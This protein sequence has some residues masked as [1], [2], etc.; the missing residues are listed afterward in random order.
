MFALALATAANAQTTSGSIA[1]TVTDPNQAAIASA[2]V[3]ITDE[4]KNFT[5]SATTDGDGR[6]VFPQVPPG[7][8]KMSIEGAGFKKLE[9]TG[10]LLVAND[11]LTLGGLAMQVGGASE[12]VT[13][14][15]EATLVQAES[16]ERSYAVQGEVV[17]NIAVNGRNFAALASI[18]QGLVTTTNNTTAN[19]ITDISANGL[20]TSANNLQIDGVATVDT[21]NNGQLVQVTLDAIAE[22]KVLTSNYQAEYGRSAGAQISAVTRSG[23][24]DFHGSFY[25]F[26]RHDGLNANTWINNHTPS[27]D[28]AGNPR[29]FTPKPKLDQRDIGYTIGGPVWIPKVFNKNKDKL[30]FFFSQE[31]QHR[32]TPPTGPT[33]VT[34]PTALERLGDFSQSVDASGAR[35]FIGDPTKK[36][37]NGNRLPCTAANTVDNLGG[38]FVSNGKL[39]VIPQGSIYQPGLNILKIYPLP[40]ANGVGFNYVTEEP[41]SAPQR[42]DLIRIDGNISNNWRANGKYLFYKNAPVQPYGSFVLGTNIPDFATVF[43]NNRYGVTGTVTGSLNPTTVLEVTFGQSHNSIDIL[44]TNPNFNRKGLNLTGVPL[45]FNDPVQLDLPPQFIF[46]GNRIANGP[47]IGSNNAPFHNFNTTRDF[48]G[49]VSK[50]WRAHNAKF[51]VFWQNSFKPQ[52]SFGANNGQYNFVNDASNPFDTGFGFSNAAVGVYN[53]FTQA[54]VYAVGNYRYNNV[55]WYAQDNWKVTSRLTLDYGMRFYW[56]QPQFDESSQTANFLFDQFR[57]SDAPRLYRPSKDAKGNR[58]G[59]DPVTG[60]TVDATSI[61]RIVPGTGKLA[62]GVPTNGVFKAGDNISQ[63]LYDNRGVQFAP[64]FGFAYDV[65]GD[66]KLVVRGGAGVFYDRPQGN[67]VF[68]LVQ[69]PP[70]YNPD[71]ALLRADTGYYPTH[72]GGFERGQGAGRA[73]QPGRHRPE[74]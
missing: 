51:G 52:S 29:N 41:T 64:R 44:P 4:S 28:E 33:R 39:N 27:A 48:A 72:A 16:A 12:T 10:I 9:R 37:A 56:I 32:L 1:G 45:L 40:N 57:A 5:I 46:N 67:T 62:N 31:Y 23:T 54:S 66:Q 53:Q 42:Q 15:A 25:A 58:I 30:F 21:G 70:D 43:Q 11:K 38:C 20:R 60:Q 65:L 36:D 22:F 6:F 2:T 68:D 8:Y 14:V 26:R 55:E 47:N 3:K 34:V 69:P 61:G 13:V 49:S 24:K 35:V 18:S 74:G 59:I 50:I 17:R 7:T 19:D 71:H 73:S 63:G